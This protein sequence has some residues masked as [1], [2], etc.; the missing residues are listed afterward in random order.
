MYP[1]TWGAPGT[2]ATA[3]RNWA[4]E[5]ALA[6][7]SAST[8]GETLSEGPPPSSWTGTPTVQPGGK[9]AG[10]RRLIRPGVSPTAILTIGTHFQQGSAMPTVTTAD[11]TEIFY[12][13][14]G[15]GHPVVFGPGWPLTGDVWV[16]SA[17][18]VASRRFRAVGHERRCGRSV[19][20]AVERQ[21]PG[22]LRRQSGRGYRRPRSHQH[23]ACRTFDGGEVSR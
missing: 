6:G 19:Q 20:P 11:G 17:N 10:G 16:G 15:A 23:G 21:R 9:G 14:W 22:S 2:A 12:Q 8:S 13:D 1:Q 4:G 18:F 7:S 5:L 3:S